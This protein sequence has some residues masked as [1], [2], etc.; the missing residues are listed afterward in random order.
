M[1]SWIIIIT[2]SLVHS[3]THS[4]THLFNEYITGH[5]DF[6]FSPYGAGSPTELDRSLKLP[7]FHKQLTKRTSPTREEEEEEAHNLVT[8]TL[9]PSLGIFAA[10]A[11]PGANELTGGRTVSRKRK[12]ASGVLKLWKTGRV[13]AVESVEMRGVHSNTT[14]AD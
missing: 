14:V 12:D 2:H 1:T 7:H 3:L 5:G 9:S 4:C 11:L 6:L 8:L 10:A 13:V